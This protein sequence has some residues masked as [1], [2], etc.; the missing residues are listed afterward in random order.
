[1][2]H[3]GWGTGPLWFAEALLIFSFGYAAWRVWRKASQR[4]MEAPLPRW[5]AWLVSALG[6]GAAALLLRQWAPIG[7]SLIGLQIGYF[8]SYIFLFALGTVAWQRNWF[9][10]LTWKMARPWMILSVVMWPVMVIALLA[11]K[12]ATGANPEVNTGLSVPAVVYALWEPLIAWGIIAALLI[13]FREWGNRA[14]AAWEFCS[15]RAYAVYI[16]HAPVLVGVAL[17]LQGWHG[18]AL[19]K[20]AVTGTLAIAGSLAVASVVMIMPG[21]RRVL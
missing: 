5:P 20:V 13:G 19:V 6:V 17:L 9:E 11:T 3:P 7:Q 8:A 14:A 10:R 4:Q 21:A 15:A 2:L 18:P 12:K 1:L 16:V